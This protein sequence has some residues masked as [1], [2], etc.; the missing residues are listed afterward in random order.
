MNS[1]TLQLTLFLPIIVLFGLYVALMGGEPEDTETPIKKADQNGQEN[2][3]ISTPE[4]DK[5]GQVT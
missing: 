1:G 4:V 2:G 3:A 5:S